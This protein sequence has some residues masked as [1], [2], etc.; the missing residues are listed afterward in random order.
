MKN[1]TELLS[2]AGDMDSL[3]AA[4]FAGADA[5]Y[6][7]GRMFG[8]RAYAKNFTDEELL[9]AID[10]VHLY[11]RKL[12]LTVNTI[13]KN[14]EIDSLKEYIEP[15]YLRGLDGV[16]VQDLGVIS[17]ISTC[18][19]GL[20]IHASTQMTI[21]DSDGVKLLENMGITR[22][23]LARELS[24]EEISRIH[25]A[26]DV[27]LE[28][29]IHGAL[30]YS[31]S[32]KCLFSS[33]VGGR[34][35][36]RGRCAQ[37]CRLPYDDTYLLSCKDICTLEIL[38]KLC[39]AGITSF[40]IEGRMKSAEYVAGVTGIYR[41]YIDLYF[42]GKENFKV[43][44]KDLNDLIN[45]Y[46]RS[47]N[48]SGYYETKNGRKMITI[49]KPCYNSASDEDKKKLFDEYTGGNTKN[50]ISGYA[51]VVLNDNISFTVNY[52]EISVTVSGVVAEPAKKK[53][54]SK[55]D[56]IK[57]LKKTGDSEFFFEELEVYLDANCF[58]PVSELNNLRRNAIDSLKGEIL[59]KY[60]RD[61]QGVLSCTEAVKEAGAVT[62][63][64]CRPFI[65]CHI[66]D[67]GYFDIIVSKKSVDI[68]SIEFNAFVKLADKKALNNL[69]LN[70]AKAIHAVGKKFTLAFPVIL[71]KR[72]FERYDLKELLLT[73]EVDGVL[74]DNYETLNFLSEIGYKGQITA[75]IHMYCMNKHA[76][77]KFQDL[78][79]TITT[80]PVELSRKELLARDVC[81]EEILCY[82]KL[83][84]MVSAQC[85]KNTTESC[86][87]DNGKTYIKDR[88]GNSFASVRDC[89]ECIN[90]IVNSVP[91]LIV[92]DE[93]FVR[94]LR[95][96]S[97]R[98]T[99][100]D[101]SLET[102][103]SV[104]D[105]YDSIVNAKPSNKL[106]LPHTTAHFNR[107]VI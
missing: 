17:L 34:S 64:Y 73:G 39:R 85:V 52:H 99:F 10:F 79:V 6:V 96:Y 41:K 75:D 60:H 9:Y 100:Y 15:L 86:V 76:I 89:N 8:A 103:S 31:Y 95:P 30:C 71:R 92:P 3:K 26:S 7:G 70:Y 23:V 82:G 37:P 18:F 81:S 33:I 88:M 16:I 104:I 13:L 2:P 40:K 19:K 43:A 53:A 35:G 25:K 83:P 32:G 105:Y 44:K 72:F 90:V 5:V 22:V 55:D 45:L 84:M 107:G 66:N 65:N 54:I 47:G 48:C 80:A 101:E 67:L 1:N 77:K 98:L 106:D 56:V 87:K 68:I 29:F 14:E 59:A 46:T 28:C 57:Q 93:T 94:K 62:V 4:I 69:I 51:V 12:Y 27:E 91:N 11:G 78:S 61:K 102:V 74:A 38:P 97:Y 36:N 42:D 63:D 21:T 20:E 24:L 50:P 58:V 49:S